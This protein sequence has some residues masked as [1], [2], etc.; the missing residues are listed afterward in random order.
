MRWLWIAAGV[1]VLLSALV[2]LIG[3]L[4]PEQHTARSRAW[5][6]RSAPDRVWAVLWDFERW[7]RWNPADTEV[8]RL[9]DRDGKAVWLHVGRYGEM[10]TVVELA[11]PPRRL[12]TRIPAEAGLGFHGT[13][14]YEIAPDGAGSRV[15]I[16][17]EGA[18]DSPL[19]R[20]FSLFS[21]PHAT[22]DATLRSLAG[23]LG[24]SALPEH[25]E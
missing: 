20:F 16:A 7:P 8:R 18:V 1:A 21:S 10:P 3:A 22:M 24:E 5:F 23:A 12:V 9:P 2:V 11:E 13:W 14:T 19:F 15:E 6:P 17:E 4:V 25:V